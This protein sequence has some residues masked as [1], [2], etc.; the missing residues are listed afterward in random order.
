MGKNSDLKNIFESYYDSILKEAVRSEEVSEDSPE[1][2]QVKQG[3]K[4]SRNE[5][6][7]QWEKITGK[8]YKELPQDQKRRNARFIMAGMRSG[9][10]Q[11]PS[12]TQQQ[13]QQETSPKTGFEETLKEFEKTH[14][15]FIGTPDQVNQLLKMHQ[16]K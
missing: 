6:I 2:D 9:Q 13:T 14:G 1:H 11:A 10:V 16:V 5:A 4:I 15:K 3:D 7:K 12:G 8:N